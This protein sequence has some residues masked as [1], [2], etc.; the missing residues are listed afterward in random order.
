MSFFR[1]AVAAVLI[2][3]AACGFRPLHAPG[4]GAEP[5][6]L[7]GIEIAHIP[8]R[9]GQVV[10]N[11]LLDRLTPRGAPAAATYRFAV[12]LRT[13]KEPLAIARDDTATRF[14]VSVE[15]DYDLSLISTGETVLQGG[16]RSVAAYDVVSSG[17]ANTVAERNAEL[18]AA[19]E[20]SDELKTRV[21]VFL[22]RGGRS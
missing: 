17:Y 4:G 8:D 18:R 6:V 9:L 21:A 20:V 16:V 2:S 11:H 22:A 1:P 3:L 12:S 5:G 15:A 19:R 13:S 7:A 10:R 14:N